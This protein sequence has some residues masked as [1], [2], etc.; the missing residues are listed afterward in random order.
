[1]IMALTALSLSSSPWAAIGSLMIYVGCFAFSMGPIPQLITSENFSHQVRGRCVSIA[2]FV[3]WICNFLVV[4]TF[5]DLV[6]YLTHAGAFLVYVCFGLVA[7]YFIWKKIPETNG[8]AL[9]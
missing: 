2:L 6:R 4:F 3:S 8:T 5:M 1:M 9:K 7:F